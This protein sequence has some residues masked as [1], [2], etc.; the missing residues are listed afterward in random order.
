[1]YIYIT[2]DV[3]VMYTYITPDP[4]VMEMYIYITRHGTS[5]RR[6]PT[7]ARSSTSASATARAPAA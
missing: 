2:S 6:R 3:M 5:A 7:S 4:R 1:M